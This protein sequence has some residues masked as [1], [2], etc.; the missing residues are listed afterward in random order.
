MC[1][2]ILCMILREPITI[3]TKAEATKSTIVLN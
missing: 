3:F 2:T 1:D